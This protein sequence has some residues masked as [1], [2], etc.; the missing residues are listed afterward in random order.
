MFTGLIAFFLIHWPKC[1]FTSSSM[2]YLTLF[3]SLI[4]TNHSSTIFSNSKCKQPSTTYLCRIYHHHCPSMQQIE[5]RKGHL[6][7]LQH[8]KILAQ[9]QL[10]FPEKSSERGV[11]HLQILT[12]HFL[13]TDLI[14][15]C[16]YF[17]LM[18]YDLLFAAC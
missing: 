16:L 9:T 15:F 13:Y 18:N 2:I 7:D 14:P 10:S 8:V 6:Y 17:S 4:A 5:H 1:I 3:P 11:S 12:G